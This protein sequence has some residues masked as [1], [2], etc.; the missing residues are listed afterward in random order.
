MSHGTLMPRRGLSQ[1]WETK[2]KA[3]EEISMIVSGSMVRRMK[4]RRMAPLFV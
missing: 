3:F 4:K 2:N 1:R